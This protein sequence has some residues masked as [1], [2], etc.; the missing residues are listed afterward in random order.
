ML[1]RRKK[2][3]YKK[4][5]NTKITLHCPQNDRIIPPD[6]PSNPIGWRQRIRIYT[7]EKAKVVAA[8]WGKEF[9]LII[10]SILPQDELKNKL[11]CT[12]FFNL[13]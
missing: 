8:S 6:G 10:I 4:F 3:A 7:E 1:Q 11:I 2:I 13:S 9:L 5:A 12:L